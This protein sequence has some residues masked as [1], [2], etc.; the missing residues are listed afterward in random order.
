LLAA[1]LG[2]TGTA[3]N[4]YQTGAMI[5]QVMFTLISGGVF[6]AV[7]VP[8]IVRTLKSKHAEDHLNKLITSSVVLLLLITF[9]LMLGTSVLTSI[10]LDARWTGEQRGLVNAF[11]LW[12]MPQ[13]FF[14][15]L[16]TILGQILAAKG[17]FGTYAWSSVGAN[18]I[19]CAGFILF[20]VLFGNA[21]RQPMQ[22]WT[23]LTIALTA[24]TWT[25]GVAFQA[26]ILFFPLFRSGFRF[27]WRWGIRGIG[28]RSMGPV[29]AWSLG[30]V[31]VNQLANVINARITNGAPLA[32]HDPFGIAG[33]GSYQ[34][35]F[36]L[37]ILPYSLI[38][39]SVTTA[40]FPKLSKAIAEHHVDQARLDLSQALRNV[41]LLMAFFSVA[42]IVMPVPITRALL[43]S[44]NI[45]E[46]VLISQPLVGLSYGL[47]IS[48]A[49]LLVQRTFYA[50]EDGLHPFI[51]AAMTN[52]LQV[53]IV[54]MATKLL[55][56]AQWTGW[57]GLSMTLGNVISFPFLIWMLRKQLGG[58]V[59]GRRIGTTYVK[60][61]ISA[62]ASILVGLLLSKPISRFV[63]ASLQ[64][65]HEHMSWF[66][67]IS[68][69]ILLC[70]VVGVVYF[71][72]LYLMKTE[73]LLNAF[74]GVSKQFERVL[75]GFSRRRAD[76]V[77][78]TPE[79]SDNLVANH[80][81]TP[82]QATVASDE[83]G[84]M[85]TRQSLD[86]QTVETSHS[87]SSKHSMTPQLGDTIIDRYALLASLRNEPGLQAW[88]AHDAVLARDCQLFFVTDGAVST[89]CSTYAS[90][91]ALSRNQHFTPV[92]HFSESEGVALIITAMDAGLSLSDYLAGAKVGTLSNEAMRTIVG[93]IAE[94]LLALKRSDL[95][96]PTICT[97]TIRLSKSGVKV[98]DAP[99]SAMLIDPL[100][101]STRHVITEE[102]VTK[103]LSAVLY[104]M[105]TRTPDVKGMTFAEQT[106]PHDTPDEFR[107]ICSRGLGLSRADGSPSVPLRTLGELEALLGTWTP[108]EELSDRDIVWPDHD[109][110]CSV[111]KVII[112]TTDSHALRDI[113]SSFGTATKAQ[114]NNAA[115]PQWATNQLLFPESD[116]VQMVRPDSTNGDLFAAFEDFP[117]IK[118][119]GSDYPEQ[120]T[121]ALDVSHL[122][123]AKP[124]SGET[125]P[126]DTGEIPATTASIPI[127][128]IHAQAAK[129]KEVEEQQDALN[130][131]MTAT[132]Q[133]L[134]PSFTPKPRSPKPD[135]NNEY[136]F[137]TNDTS[138][139]ESG[140]KES[141]LF[142]IFSGRTLAILVGIVLIVGALTWAVNGLLDAT[143]GSSDTETNKSTWPEMTN[144]PFRSTDSASASDS[145]ASSSTKASSSASATKSSTVTVTHDDKQAKAVPS[146][147]PTPTAT[148]N[149]TPYAT[150][151]QT[152]LSQPAGLSGRGWYVHLTQPQSVSRLVISI[153]Q[154]GGQGQVYAN[155]TAS[156]PN[157]GTP[158]AQFSFDA[159][160]TTT[161]KFSSPVSTQDLVIWVPL[162]TTPSGGL[163]FNSVQ[164]Y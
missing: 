139:K 86:N 133:P 35:A 13:I 98:A 147:S 134:P 155:S 151:T 136:G 45:H 82:E 144:V 23:P 69:C 89:Q 156:S 157:Q 50:L 140:N 142:G 143:V 67:S 102:M 51:F 9:I 115:E 20:I 1:A 160:G 14:Y 132:M 154:S 2:T 38:A 31:V 70:I 138:D 33:N 111:E 42:M 39:V 6:N 92:Y 164:V 4:A 10:Y 76:P 80:V 7:L 88:R 145:A 59:D 43:P 129:I 100:G 25:V 97:D 130:Q 54:L 107:I 108:P 101:A 99:I 5:P 44:V 93:E 27:R 18:V 87:E 146:P 163:Y 56:P 32:G 162:D 125:L 91:L 96:N 120:A 104:A 114:S 112:R 131:E 3:I 95:V 46:A 123:A 149:T 94:A 150:G 8:Q 58:S 60:I 63:G 66:Q 152:Y 28:L 17:K 15:G 16:Y 19:S 90:G 117:Y 57:V 73:E 61:L 26:V 153:R 137:D 11:T 103:Q 74:Q 24:G 141:K 159:S 106:L 135:S 72:L 47:V 122:R 79:L 113:P 52:I 84:R 81:K 119:I 124:L 64:S 158:V 128:T 41:G 161:V 118:P 40:M 77:L 75:K 12:C 83:T 55:P 78:D 109:G 62:I 37:Y 71:G 53:G 116:E 48:G 34:N 22:F 126:T 30:V 148:E 105:L 85:S 29:A 127:E 121:S 21:Q 36:A 68:I 65:G 110:A 49:F